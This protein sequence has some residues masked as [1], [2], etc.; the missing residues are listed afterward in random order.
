M[1]TR[2][3]LSVAYLASGYRTSPTL[4]HRIIG[5]V[6]E[7]R[8]LFLKTCFIQHGL[9]ILREA[10]GCRYLDIVVCLPRYSCS[11]LILPI[12]L[13]KL[14]SN[15]LTATEYSALGLVSLALVIALHC[16][17]ATTRKPR[18]PPQSLPKCTPQ[19]SLQCDWHWSHN[20]SHASQQGRIPCDSDM[21]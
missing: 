14:I 13:K 2:L 19:P 11:R 7:F 21:D 5:P 10:G 18:L 4:A 17:R 3:A 12:T 8:H 20:L 1:T 9:V 15:H 16:G 6:S